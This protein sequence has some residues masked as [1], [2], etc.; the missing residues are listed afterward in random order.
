MGSRGRRPLSVDH[1]EFLLNLFRLLPAGEYS[2]AS[3]FRAGMPLPHRRFHLEDSKRVRNRLRHH[4]HWGT[5]LLFWC[6]V[7]EQTQVVAAGNL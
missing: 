7:E 5:R 1:K 6:V 2:A 3:Q 4:R